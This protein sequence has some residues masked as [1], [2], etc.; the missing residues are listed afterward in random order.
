[1][2]YS[3]LYILMY[4]FLEGIFT[5]KCNIVFVFSTLSK[6]YFQTE[7]MF[8]HKLSPLYNKILSN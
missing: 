7:I 3:L 6:I 5:M 4:T 1:M 8:Y 2:N